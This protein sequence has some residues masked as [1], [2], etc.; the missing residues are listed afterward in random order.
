MKSP[1]SNSRSS[2]MWQNR[3]IFKPCIQESSCDPCWCFFALTWGQVRYR[4]TEISV[5]FTP[6]PSSVPFWGGSPTPP[7]HQTGRSHL[8]SI[9]FSMRLAV[10]TRGALPVE[11]ECSSRLE[12]ISC[13]VISVSAAVP[14]P[15]QLNK[16]TNQGALLQFPRSCCT[17]SV[18]HIVS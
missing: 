10:A 4:M 3:G 17:T 18:V 6:A 2:K 9:C 11:R 14:A 7:P 13:V 15:Q 5:F 1:I 16:I 12:E 8:K